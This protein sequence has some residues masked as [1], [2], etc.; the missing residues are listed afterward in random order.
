MELLEVAQPHF[1]VSDASHERSI[2]WTPTRGLLE[3]V[4]D[5]AVLLHL[6]TGGV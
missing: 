4:E 3:R 2:A 6:L 5:G 1:E